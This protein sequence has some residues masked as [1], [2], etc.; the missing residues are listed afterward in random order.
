MQVQKKIYLHMLIVLGVLLFVNVLIKDGYGEWAYGLY[1]E[2]IVILIAVTTGLIETFAKDKYGYNWKERKRFLWLMG[3]P[4]G[5]LIILNILKIVLIQEAV[6][7]NGQ[8]TKSGSH[9]VIEVILMIM[10]FAYL[11]NYIYQK[12]HP[13]EN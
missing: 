4:C 13:K 11:G 1:E 5:A 7:L 12:R 8:L 2:L 6:W 9:F 10:Y 3:V